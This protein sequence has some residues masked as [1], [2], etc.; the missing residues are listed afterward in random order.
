VTDSETFYSS[1]LDVFDD[2]EEQ[3]EVKDLLSWWNRYGSPD[4]PAPP[5]IPVFSQIF[6]NYAAPRC[7]LA[8]NSALARIRAKRAISRAGT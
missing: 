6:P 8:K 4:L 2:P 7:E 5:L 1:I 3:E